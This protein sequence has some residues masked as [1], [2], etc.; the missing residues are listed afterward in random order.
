MK[1]NGEQQFDN[2]PYHDWK[3]GSVVA[4]HAKELQG[5]TWLE[6]EQAG[7]MVPHDQ[8]AFALAMLKTYLN[9]N[10]FE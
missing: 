2:L 4:G 1:W 3:V 5:F 8:P 10:P 9:N 6:F 7:H